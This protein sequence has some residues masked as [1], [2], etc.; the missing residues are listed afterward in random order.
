MKT[1]VTRIIDYITTTTVL[2]SSTVRS[3]KQNP[4]VYS[5]DNICNNM[6]MFVLASNMQQEKEK[7][8]SAE[9]GG[10]V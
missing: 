7:F 9:G 10:G 3:T 8:K 5:F 4:G 1:T 2:L 6:Y